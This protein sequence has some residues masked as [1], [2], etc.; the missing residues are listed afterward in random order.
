VVSSA[1]PEATTIGAAVLEQGGNAVDAAIAISLALGVSEPAGSGLAGQTVMLV[2]SPSGVTE[3]IHGTTWSPAAL[4]AQV[5]TAQLR[6]GHSAASVPST[7]KVLDLALRRYGSGA[8]S[9]AELVTPAAALADDGVILGPFRARAF[10][11]YGAALAEQDAA[12][13]LFLHP[14]GR[15]WIAGDRFRQPVLAQT[16]RRLAEAGAEDFYRGAIA[17]AI[18]EDMAAN[19]GWITAE[20]LAAFP[21]PAIVEPLRAT[22]RGYEIATLPPPFGGWVLLQ[23]MKVLEQ[24][25]LEPR[26]QPGAPRQ[27]QLLE[28]MRLAHGTRARDPVPSF[29]NYGEDI[30]KKISEAEAARLWSEK[31]ETTH[32]SVVDDQGW[33][34][35]V[36]QSIDSYF[37]AKVAHPTLG[38]LY[39]NYMQGFRL[40]DDGS[41]YVLKPKEMVLSSM[42]GTIVSE[43]DQP[44]LVLGSP[45][46]ERIISAVAQVTS[47]WLDLSRNLKEAVGAY[48]VHG[49]PK[50]AAF[51]EGP[52]LSQ[53]LLA[54]LVRA[55]FSLERPRYGVSDSYLDPYFGGV[56]AIAWEGGR[57]VGAADPRRDGAV[58]TVENTR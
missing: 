14:E 56:H 26:Q 6:R 28:A 24:M 32:F 8:F 49:T 40:E 23:L 5:T 43:A 7:P 41:P 35:A 27:L 42:T 34:V 39:N 46:S 4:P 13:R 31:G 33:V 29:T 47:H 55:G 57:W 48:R 38:F 30:A 44:L 21:E 52:A 45:G 18:A 50:N 2:R 16:L 58:R 15:P 22:Y 53:A 54:G 3:V 17:Q 10:Q 37:G 1:T 20:D 9:W 25:P 36:T 51:I 19:G 11:F 12:R